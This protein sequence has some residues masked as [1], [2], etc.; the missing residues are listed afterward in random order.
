MQTINVSSL[1]ANL[2]ATLK[3]ANHGQK[4]LVVD[5]ST[6]LA[7]ITPLD[8]NVVF[9]QTPQK[10]IRPRPRNNLIIDTDAADL[11]IQERRR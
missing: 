4:I 8:E 2:S 5:R 11:L 3:K 6:P 7:H 1:K 10:K 9:V